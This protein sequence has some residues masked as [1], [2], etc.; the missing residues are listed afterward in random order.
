MIVIN[1]MLNINDFNND[2]PAGK[3]EFSVTEISNKI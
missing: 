1:I 3:N 2:M